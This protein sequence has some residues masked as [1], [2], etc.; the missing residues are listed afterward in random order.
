MTESVFAGIGLVDIHTDLNRN[1]VSMRVSQNLFDDLSDDPEHWRSAI[2]LELAT[3][4]PLFS[5]ASPI[6]DRPF[7]EAAWNDAINYPF[8][9]WQRSRYSDG[10]FGVW[11]G[12]DC[13]ETSVHETVHHW[14]KG[15]LQD[16]GMTQPGIR[17][18]RTVYQ[19]RCDAALLDLRPIVT[20]LPA[21][22]DG[23]DYA[24]TQ[25]IGARLHREGHPG[26][27]TRSARCNG[28]IYPV[29]NRRVLSTPRQL[30]H[31]SYVTM[32]DGVAVERDPGPYWFVIAD[33]ERAL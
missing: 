11:Y 29:F 4:P 24:F 10:S 26:L 14:R 23:E 28:D 12:A 31:L 30:C 9:H 18:E 19:V 32:A 3:K 7:E 16:A 22:V 33:H 5:S 15:F 21:L 8:S 13:I 2:A 1:I 25:Q 17:V 27:L 6:I 20:R